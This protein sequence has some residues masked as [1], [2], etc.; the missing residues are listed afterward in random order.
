MQG[1]FVTYPPCRITCN[2][3]PQTVTEAAALEERRRE[4]ILLPAKE[5][6]QIR[7]VIDKRIRHI[8]QI[9]VDK[10]SHTRISEYK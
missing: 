1:G 8:T 4:T 2:A 6:P 9:L 3:E 5:K 7:S 10:Q